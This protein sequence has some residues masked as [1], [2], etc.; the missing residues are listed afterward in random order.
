MIFLENYLKA[1]LL[2][3]GF[4]LC[5]VLSTKYNVLLFSIIG[6]L[7]VCLEVLGYFRAKLISTHQVNELSVKVDELSDTVSGK[8]ST[9]SSDVEAI[10]DYVGALK[11]RR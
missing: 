5:A 8:I 2:F 9:M 10:K 6:I 1:I 11:M 3:A 7:V 4:V